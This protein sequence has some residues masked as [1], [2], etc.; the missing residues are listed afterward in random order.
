MFINEL[1]LLVNKCVV[2]LYTSGIHFYQIII[3]LIVINY[4]IYLICYMT[5]KMKYRRF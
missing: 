2:S 4:L 1:A 3:G 5:Y